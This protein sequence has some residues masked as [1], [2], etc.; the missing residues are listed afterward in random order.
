MESG[1]VSHWGRRRQS[2]LRTHKSTHSHVCSRTCTSA[3]P[4]PK[5]S[6]TAAV[7]SITGKSI[8]SRSRDAPAAAPA[9]PDPDPASAPAA[10][11]AT[12]SSPLAVSNESSAA[13]CPSPNSSAAAAA[14]V[15]CPHSGTSTAGVNQRSRKCEH[16]AKSSASSEAEVASF[17]SVA[18]S[19]KAVSERFISAAMACRTTSSSGSAGRGSRTT[20]AGFPPKASGVKASICAVHRRWPVRGWVVGVAVGGGGRRRHQCHSAPAFGST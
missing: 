1:G 8:H 5:P 6:G 20:A 13:G 9:S 14:S 12:R 10:W 16:S 11:R 18:H 19:T 2:L 4:G 17:S 3:D 15:A 7:A